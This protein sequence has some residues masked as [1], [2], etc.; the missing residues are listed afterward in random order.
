MK[1]SRIKKRITSLL[2]TLCITL[3]LCPARMTARAEDAYNVIEI[4]NST[5][6]GYQLSGNTIYTV[7]GDVNINA[8]G[9]SSKDALSVQS[10]ATAYLVLMP[11][12]KLTVTGKNGSYATGGGAGINVPSNSTLYLLGSGTVIATGGSGGSA[13]NGGKGAD[14]WVSFSGNGTLKAGEGGN[15]GNGGGGGGAGIGGNGGNGG[16]G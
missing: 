7:S 6:A 9:S 11:G 12:S 14:A 13:S 15:G 3:M 10:G 8:N 4:N 1:E 16:S 2:L 5:A